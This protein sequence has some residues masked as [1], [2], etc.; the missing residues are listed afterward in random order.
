[1]CR[2]RGLSEMESKVREAPPLTLWVVPK[3]VPSALISKE[4]GSTGVRGIST[5]RPSSIKPARSRRAWAGPISC[6]LIP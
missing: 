3:L 1:M 2:D 5:Y 4:R 6:V